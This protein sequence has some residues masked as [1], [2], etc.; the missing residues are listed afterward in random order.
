[1]PLLRGCPWP[2]APTL[3]PPPPPQALT[4]YHADV[5]GGQF[6]SQ[7]Y[8]PYKIAASEAEQLLRELEREGLEGA[9]EAVLEHS[10][11]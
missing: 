6:P 11:S 7:A 10:R 5:V 8:S 4:A 3:A 2:P 9:A 1:M